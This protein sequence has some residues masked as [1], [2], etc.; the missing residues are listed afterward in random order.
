MKYIR[1]KDGNIYET[2]DL[3][4]CEDSR[5][6]NGWFTESGVPLTAIK[7][8]DNIEDLLDETVAFYK[9][10]AKFHWGTYPIKKVIDFYQ[11][12]KSREAELDFL[13]GYIWVHDNLTKV[14]KLTDEGWK[15]EYGN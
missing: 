8:S 11:I 5:F 3:I 15:L 12:H 1:T 10:G 7:E 14:A 4:K 6:P 9:D 13:G 2:K